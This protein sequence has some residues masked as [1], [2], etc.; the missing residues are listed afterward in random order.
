MLPADKRY[1]VS[2]GAGSI[3]I[4]TG[5]IAAIESPDTMAINAVALPP[6]LLQAIVVLGPKTSE[7][8]LIEAVGPAWSGI[9]RIL[10]RD[11]SEIYKI[12]PRRLEEM[13]AAWYEQSGFDQVVLTPRSGDGGR[14]VI[15]E[16]TGWGSVRF[17]D[18]V[19]AYRA[20]FLVTVEE[21]R[22]LS[23]VLAA[24]LRAN[25]GVVTTTSDFAP[26]IRQDPSIAPFLPTRI[27]LVNGTELV[28]RLEALAKDDGS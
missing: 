6:V 7:G 14:D 13:I 25:K 3:T 8:H 4:T 28:E 16:K 2:P 1:L 27:E 5:S 15:A 9:L 23:G 26:R 24:D 22:A 10:R 20:G 12:P 18:Q 11:P 21:V 19:K 17:I